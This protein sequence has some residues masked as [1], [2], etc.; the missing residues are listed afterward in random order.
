V[1][2]ESPR[3]GQAA[4]LSQ[5]AWNVFAVVDPATARVIT[6]ERRVTGDLEFQ[7]GH[8]LRAPDWSG[9]VTSVRVEP[10]QRLSTGDPVVVVAGVPRIAVAS[11]QPFYRF[12]RAE[13]RG[14]DVAELNDALFRLGYLRPMPRQPDRFLFDTVQAVRDLEIALGFTTTSG[15][16]D[17]A[18]FV[19]LP[20]EPFEIGELKLVAG[21]RPPPGG[22]EFASE[23]RRLTRA[24]VAA[25]S[26][27]ENLVLDPAV[28]WV[29]VVGTGRFPV[30]PRTLEVASGSLSALQ[31]ALPPDASRLD[32]TLQRAEPLNVVAVPSTAIVTGR[33]GQL[34]AWLPDGRGG[35]RAQPVTVAGARGGVT[36]VRTGIAAG[37]GVLANPSEVLGS[38]VCP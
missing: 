3:H 38:P 37:E 18:W 13:D 12:L 30:D 34:C 11:S 8:A 33:T 21:A 24:V 9:T 6:D 29:L 15:I 22:D 26:P 2:A 25:A 17:P 20:F 4:G 35:Y 5:W 32:G 27:Q 23:P 7:D 19:W 16:F 31:K 1:A 10:G 28:E 14:P 36:N